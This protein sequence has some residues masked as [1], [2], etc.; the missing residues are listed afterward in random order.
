MDVL[1][2]GI[3]VLMDFFLFPGHVVSVIEIYQWNMGSSRAQDAAW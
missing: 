2:E 3:Y 1:T